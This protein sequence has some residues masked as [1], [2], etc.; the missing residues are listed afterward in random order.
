MAAV[1]KRNYYHC[2]A[3]AN[4]DKYYLRD[5]QNILRFRRISPGIEKINLFIAIS[6]ATTVKKSDYI[7]VWAVKRI[8][9]TSPNIVLRQIFFKSNL[10]R[11][12]SSY[13]EMSAIVK[14]EANPDDFVFFQNRSGFGPFRNNWYKE[15]ISQFT[16]FESTA[17]CGSTINFRDHPNR[18]DRND[19]AHVQTYAFLTQVA[20]LRMLGDNFPGAEENLRIN[21]IL[22]GEIGLSQFFIDRGYGV[23]CME[24]PEALVSKKTEPIVDT[25]VKEEITKEHQF[26]H[27][28]YV[29]KKE[30]HEITSFQK[31]HQYLKFLIRSLF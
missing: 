3:T 4:D 18:S 27:R 21:I 16:K 10:G 11:D 28:T 15:I 9:S 6:K 26:H 14:K 24:W 25:D 17:L 29:L 12:F 20:F 23:T 19:C 1:T 5:I 22:K 13:A 8:L 30:K 7:F 2:Y 31:S